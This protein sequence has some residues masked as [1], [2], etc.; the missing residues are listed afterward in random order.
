[1]EIDSVSEDDEAEVPAELVG[2]T[3]E[4]VT[5]TGTT[6]ATSLPVSPPTGPASRT[7]E[8]FGPPPRVYLNVE[9]IEGEAN[10]G[11]LY[12]VY[13][14]VPEGEPPDPDGAHFAGTM[15]FFGIEAAGTDDDDREEAPHNL[16]HVFDITSL[17]A[18]LTEQ[19]HW[20]PE[21]LHVTFSPLGV[22]DESASALEVPPVRI[23]RVSL[24]MQ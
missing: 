24:F 22:E 4:A 8:S 14:N 3:E 12:G 20:D 17:A 11:L 10:P 19:G 2:A 9:N 6:T 5:L 13:V 23:G 7:E 1:M 15:S 18:T 21:H 16:R